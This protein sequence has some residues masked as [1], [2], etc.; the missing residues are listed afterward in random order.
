MFKLASLS[1]IEHTHYVELIGHLGEGEASCIALAKQRGAV[2]VTEDRMA[3]KQ[4]QQMKLQAT[5]TIGI[6]KASSLAGDISLAEADEIL[7]GMIAAG[8]YSPVRNISDI[9]Q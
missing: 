8:F 6:S 1:S 4:Y 5:G 9:V 7:H 3:R 2:V